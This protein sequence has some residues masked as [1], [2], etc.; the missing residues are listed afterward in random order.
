ME[1]FLVC[2]ISSDI[3]TLT[4]IVLFGICKLCRYWLFADGA[5]TSVLCNV[6]KIFTVIMVG[7]Y[8]KFNVRPFRY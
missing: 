7:Y 1:K 2:A 6:A 5:G 8:H 3:I 4:I